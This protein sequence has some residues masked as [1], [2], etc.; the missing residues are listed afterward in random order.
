MSEAVLTVASI[1]DPSLSRERRDLLETLRN[2]RQFLKGTTRD[3]T[4]EQANTRSTVSALTLG[5]LIKHVSEV[6]QQ[7]ARFAALGPEAFAGEAWVDVDWETFEAR[8]PEALGDDV[9]DAW[10]AGFSMVPGETLAEL[11][12]AYDEIAAATDELVAT[13]P[14]LDH[15]HPLPKAPWFEQDATWSMRRVFTHIVAE[16]AQH[17]GHADIIRE[18]ID[19]AKSM[20]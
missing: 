8:G 19:G 18:S 17:S 14:D 11:I 7:W 1:N 13:L 3:L 12:A 10:E 2:Q 15:A 4:D 5:G 6:E 20:G 16:T 9:I